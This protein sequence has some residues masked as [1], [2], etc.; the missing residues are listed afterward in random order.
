M[1]SFSKYQK[2][3]DHSDKEDNIPSMELAE[4]LKARDVMKQEEN[5][6]SNRNSSVD[7]SGDSVGK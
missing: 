4:C 5:D 2:E 1:I 7:E 3:R 6:E